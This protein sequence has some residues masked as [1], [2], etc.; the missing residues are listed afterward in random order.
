MAAHLA[1]TGRPLVITDAYRDYDEQVDVAHRKP[2]LAANPGYSKHGWGLAVDLVV[3]G[4]SG[5]TFLW[6]TP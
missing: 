5:Q 6:F 2:P 1:D 3:D 4:W